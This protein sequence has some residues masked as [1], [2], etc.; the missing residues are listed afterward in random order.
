VNPAT[1]LKGEM[2]DKRSKY[3][4]DPLDPDFARRTEALRGGATEGAAGAA[5][6]EARPN[7]H[8]EEPTRRFYEPPRQAAQHAETEQFSSSYPSVFVPPVYQPPQ[9]GHTSFGAGAP[10][11]Q[12]AHGA[13]QQPAD[14]ARSK[15]TKRPVQKLGVPEN[16]ALILPYAPFYIGLVA[17]IV[18]LLLAP[19][20][21]TRARFHAAQGLA[22]QLVLV[23]GSFIFGI[24]EAITDS[25]LG[26]SLFWLAS[27]IFLVV[28]MIRVWEGKPHHIAP[29]DDL[30]QKINAKFEPRK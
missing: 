14:A 3:D 12:Q 6:E 21:E 4:T 20:T 5:R 30:T 17:A 26:G 9:P 11:P 19:R 7:P 28:S 16:V 22:L 25:G 1:R 29:L 2:T 13:Y 27:T 24:V 18:V 23:A 15:P 10:G 8:A